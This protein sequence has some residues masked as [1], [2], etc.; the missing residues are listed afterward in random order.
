MTAVVSVAE[1]VDDGVSFADALGVTFDELFAGAG[2]CS[3]AD[4]EAFFPEKGCSVREA[5]ALCNGDGRC[6]WCD[7]PHAGVNCCGTRSR[8]SK[9]PCECTAEEYEARLDACPVRLACL[10]YALDT[11]ERFG[12]WGGMSDRERRRIRQATRSSDPVSPAVALAVA[13]DSVPLTD[14]ERS[15]AAVRLLAQR[16]PDRDRINNLGL[17]PEALAALEREARGI[18]A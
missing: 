6:L 16:K 7:H 4:P 10:T 3:S 2:V 12:I 1:T 18:A 13:G 17:D 15:E 8:R 5:K 14:R 9:Q 11:D